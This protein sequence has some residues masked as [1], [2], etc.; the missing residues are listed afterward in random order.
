LING[1][2]PAANPLAA[3]QHCQPFRGRQRVERQLQGA[4]EIGL[5]RVEGIDDLLSV[6]RTHVRMITELT[7]KLPQVCTG[8]TKVTQVVSGRAAPHPPVPGPAG[9]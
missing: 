3:L 6:T 1:W 5:E 4:V 2:Q 8:K 9:D 7:D